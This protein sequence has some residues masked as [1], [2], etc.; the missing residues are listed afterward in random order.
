LR[1]KDAFCF[2][3]RTTLPGLYHARDIL[4]RINGS[5]GRWVTIR[6]AVVIGVLDEAA[7]RSSNGE[8]NCAGLL[9][10]Y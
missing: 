3:Q 10:L 2:R 6:R 8:L 5:R 1:P 4:P 9:K 7:S